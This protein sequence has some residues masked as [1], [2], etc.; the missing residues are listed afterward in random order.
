MRFAYGNEPTLQFG[1][2]V[3][4]SASGHVAVSGPVQYV[5][6]DALLDLQLIDGRSVNGK[7]L[8]W[9]SEFGVGML[10]ITDPGEWPYVKLSKRAEVGEVCVALGYPANSPGTETFPGIRLGIVT[11]VADGQWLTTSDRSRF[12]AHPIFNLDGELLGLQRSWSSG[13]DSVHAAAG[14]IETHWDELAAGSNL[15]RVRLFSPESDST[16]PLPRS[17]EIDSEVISKATMASVQISDIGAE[18]NRVS[19]VIVTWRRIC[20]HLRASLANA[21]DEHDCGPSRWPISERNCSGHKS[22]RGCW[23]AEDHRRRNLAL[24]RNGPF[25][26]LG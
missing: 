3:I 25:H 5:M 13:R 14:V 17:K 4:V 23:R 6:D 19:G 15:D 10:K 1:C 20:D 12:N 9:S 8:G 26:R 7:A 11:Q 22:Y 21:R 18:E 2:G 16:R 24:L